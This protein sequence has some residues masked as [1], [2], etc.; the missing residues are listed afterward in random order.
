MRGNCFV[1]DTDYPVRGEPDLCKS[2]GVFGVTTF[3]NEK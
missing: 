3:G 1:A 2:G